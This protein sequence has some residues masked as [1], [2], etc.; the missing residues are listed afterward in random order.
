MNSAAMLKP[1]TTIAV[2]SNTAITSQ[3]DHAGKGR[4]WKDGC[5]GS[6]LA[7]SNGA[8]VP[9]P[10]MS[11]GS[12]VTSGFSLGSGIRF[13]TAYVLLLAL[14]ERGNSLASVCPV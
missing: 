11:P 3:P 2:T 8:V 6:G 10:D 7:G 13:D 9:K 5:V 4:T 14:D 1:N 12:S